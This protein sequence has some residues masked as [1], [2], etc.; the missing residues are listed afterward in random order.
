[1]V[2]QCTTT[3]LNHTINNINTVQVS[4]YV[5][6]YSK[7]Q[8]NYRE[9]HGGIRGCAGERFACS[10]PINYNGVFNGPLHGT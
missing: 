6:Y 8:H 3:V 5:H 4:I 1:M 2:A 10:V 7:K 9:I